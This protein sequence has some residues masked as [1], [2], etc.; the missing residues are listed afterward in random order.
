MARPKPLGRIPSEDSWTCSRCKF[1]NG[2]SLNEC[3]SCGDPRIFAAGINNR[4]ADCN[5]GPGNAITDPRVLWD[6]ASKKHL[7]DKCF[8]DMN[9][10]RAQDGAVFLQ[11]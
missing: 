5:V 3:L 1:R 2:V 4:C 11:T 10:R 9:L 8:R 6:N 7:C